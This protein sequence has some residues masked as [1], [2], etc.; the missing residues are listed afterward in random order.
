[1]PVR[2][3]GRLFHHLYDNEHLPV[4]LYFF[5]DICS[6]FTQQKEKE[7]NFVAISIECHRLRSYNS[8]F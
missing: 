1:M 5:L 6:N 7:T 4:E 3:P 2:H 8:I